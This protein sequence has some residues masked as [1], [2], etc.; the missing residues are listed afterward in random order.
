MDG[1]E[2]NTGPGAGVYKWRSR[3]GH[4]FRLSL[5]SMVFVAEICT[6][7]VCILQNIDMVYTGKNIYS[8]CQ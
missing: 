4:S 6:I 3:R 8:F 1:S 7:K 5:H 2:I